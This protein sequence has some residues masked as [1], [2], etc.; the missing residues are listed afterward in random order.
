MAHN[1]YLQQASDSGIPGFVIYTTFVVGA[2]VFLYQKGR[3]RD[4]RLRFATWM[5]L[6]AWSLQSLI[7]FNLYV[8]AL[9]WLA[10]ALF[11]WLVGT[12]KPFDKSV[13]PE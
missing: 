1:D 3:V 5:G 6:L 12:V 11:G 2:L 7:E 10:L 8:P 9:A 4:H 13:T